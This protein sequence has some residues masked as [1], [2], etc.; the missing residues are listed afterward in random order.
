MRAAQAYRSMLDT[1]AGDVDKHLNLAGA[2][3]IQMQPQRGSSPAVSRR[4][5][6]RKEK[7]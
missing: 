5:Q 6:P 1:L 3:L 4:V 7:N 2:V